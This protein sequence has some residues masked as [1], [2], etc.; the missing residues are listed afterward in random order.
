MDSGIL[1]HSKIWFCVFFFCQVG[2]LKAQDLKREVVAEKGDGIYSLLDKNGLDPGIHMPQFIELNRNG[3]RTDNFL[4]EGA[5]YMLPVSGS[6]A[7]DAGIPASANRPEIVEYPLFGEK[8]SKVTVRDY[9][10][11]G[12]V[13]YLISGH[14]GPD[15]GA[16]TRYGGHTISEDEYAYDVTLRLARRLMEHGARVYMIVKGPEKGIRSQHVLKMDQNEIVY[17]DQKIPLNQR[18]RLKQRTDTVNRLYAEHTETFQR[19]IEIHLDSRSEGKNIDVFFYHHHNSKYGER[20]ASH[21]HQTFLSKYAMHQPGRN[22]DGTVTTRSG[23]YVL[24]RA[25]P[26]TVFIELGNMRNQRDQ[27][28]FIL[29]DNRQALANWIAEG[30]ITDYNI[31]RDDATAMN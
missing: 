1:H 20:L 21:I 15:P 14:A 8:Y 2:L 19:V 28:R 29:P 5:T 18:A 4:I 24:R 27:L 31:D 11:K 23:L 3:L 12:A 9:K 25:Y 6:T 7:E 10:L 26:P 22:Y 13:Y 30:I 17:P 16:V